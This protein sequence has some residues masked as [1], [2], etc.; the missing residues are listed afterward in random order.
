MRE[1]FTRRTREV[2]VSGLERP[3]VGVVRSKAV[4]WVK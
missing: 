2:G 4:Q 1:T 3:I